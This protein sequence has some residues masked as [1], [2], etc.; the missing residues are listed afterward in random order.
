METKEAK[1]SGRSDSSRK[2]KEYQYVETAS[3]V[4]AG[5]TQTLV[6]S[7]DDLAVY[8]RAGSATGFIVKKIAGEGERFPLLVRQP[9]KILNI[10]VCEIEVEGKDKIA[11]SIEKPEGSKDHAAFWNNLRNLRQGKV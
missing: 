4:A 7:K 2:G 1:P 10:R 9:G 3:K 5:I 6:I 11:V 8:L